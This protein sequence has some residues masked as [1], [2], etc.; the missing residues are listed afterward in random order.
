MYVYRPH[1][2]HDIWCL[3]MSILFLVNRVTENSSR[4]S[5]VK[6]VKGWQ[7]R[8]LNEYSNQI[9][10]TKNSNE[11]FDYQDFYQWQEDWFQMIHR[12][13][14]FSDRQRLAVGRIDD[15]GI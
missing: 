2:K 12:K 3:G 13:D 10:V 15:T 5:L 1:P 9:K 7:E 14:L 4:S 8:V 11:V 6:K